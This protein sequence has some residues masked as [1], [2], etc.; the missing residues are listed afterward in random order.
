M[1]AD[2]KVFAKALAAWG[3]SPAYLPPVFSPQ[4]LE[5]EGGK[6]VEVVSTHAVFSLLSGAL[7][8]CSLSS[9]RSSSV[10]LSVTSFAQVC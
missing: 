2:P 1:L 5:L 9:S 7:L 8:A 10:C 6:L 4:M 3:P